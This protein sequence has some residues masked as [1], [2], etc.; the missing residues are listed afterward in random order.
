MLENY[1]KLADLA[2]AYGGV[3]GSIA[4]FKSTPQ[5][6]IVTEQLD[7]ELTGEG[8]HQWL[9]IKA[10]DMNTDF[11]VKQLARAF[12]VERRA[13]SYSGK[14]DRR[15]VTSQWFSVHVPGVAL[16]IPNEIHPNLQVLSS[17]RHNK[18]LRRGA[19]QYNHFEI[20]LRD[21]LNIDPGSFNSRAQLIGEQGFPNYFGAQRF[22]H[23]ENNI[24]FACR[25]IESGK[26]LKRE[27]RDR[28]FSTLRSW[29]FNHCLHLR[30]SDNSWATFQ[31]GDLLQLSGSSSFFKPEAWDSELQ[32]RLDAGDITIAGILPGKGSLATCYQTDEYILQYLIRQKLEQSIRALLVK[33]ANFQWEFLTDQILLSF[34][35]PKGAYATSLLRELIGLQ[36][37]RS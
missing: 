10:E 26:R 18:K 23:G 17:V 25:A 8:E 28:V 37:S 11:T 31:A 35:L 5:D 9:Y 36:E 4:T 7:F 16:D 1:P 29:D 33:P 12:N 27:E 32:Q 21:P 20:C 3:G 22:G 13:I 19:H 34:D 30:V 2:Y 15:A 6:F 14:K 24:A